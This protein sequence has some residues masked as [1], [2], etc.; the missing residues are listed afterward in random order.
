MQPKSLQLGVNFV[1]DETIEGTKLLI[2][3]RAGLAQL[4]EQ[5]ICNYIFC[6]FSLHFSVNPI[7]SNPL[8]Y[9]GVTLTV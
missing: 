5:L 9:L 1:T 4:V 6:L 8:E 2:S 7:P 3:L